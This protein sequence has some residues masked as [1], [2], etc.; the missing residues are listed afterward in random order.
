MAKIFYTLEEAAEKLGL[1]VDRVKQMTKAGQLQQ[2]LDRDKVMFKRDQVDAMA[3]S[4]STGMGD[5]GE[6]TLDP[7][8]SGTAALDATRGGTGSIPLTDPVGTGSITLDDSGDTGVISMDPGASGTENI[9]LADSGDTG[10]MGTDAGSSG[11]GSIPLADSGDT[12][13]LSGLTGTGL[14]DSGMG[15][16]DSAT[17]SDV[18]SLDAGD[19]ALEGSGMGGS[20][21]GASGLRGSELG[22]GEELGG[23]GG[24]A[25]GSSGLL[26][27][28]GSGLGGGSGL[29]STDLGLG[30]GIGSSGLLGDDD[31]GDGTGLIDLAEDPTGTRNGGKHDAK[32]ASGISVFD[33]DEVEHADPMAQ[34]I[35]ADGIGRSDDMALDSVGSGSGLLELTREADDTSL[36]AELLDEIYPGG[37][38]TTADT[39]MDTA[40]GSSGVFDGSVTI[41]AKDA[42]GME[43]PEAVEAVDAVEPEAAAEAEVARQYVQVPM[44]AEPFDPAGSGLASGM[45]LIT[46]AALVVAM[47]VAFSAIAGIPNSI[48]SA[49]SKDTN[50]IYIF[51]GGGVGAALICGVLGMFISKAMNK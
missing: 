17:G 2:Y 51:L 4:A 31:A 44:G 42:S 15:L 6:I 5:T 24:S 39:R 13:D 3:A 29:G 14:G 22:G 28:L 37:G 21:L 16:A 34:T 18:I 38:E 9:P 8:E 40:T 35:M 26:S 46:T 36:G 25:M 27:G 49:L 48:T 33:A 7:G 47:I 32:Q 11:T 1:S 43:L 50:T 10:L 30:S 45:M 20:V 19:S 41:E 23:P 12:G